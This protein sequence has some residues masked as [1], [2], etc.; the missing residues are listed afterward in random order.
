MITK[1]HVHQHQVD[2]LTTKQTH[3][4][5]LREAASRL[6]RRAGHDV[7]PH[8]FIGRTDAQLVSVIQELENFLNNAEALPQPVQPPKR[9]GSRGKRKTGGQG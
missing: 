3:S 9:S 4:A 8:H 1:D 5:R 7:T 6:S 2:E